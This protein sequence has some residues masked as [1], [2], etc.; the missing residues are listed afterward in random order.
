MKLVDLVRGLNL[1]PASCLND[2]D[3]SGIAYNSQNVKKGFLFVAIK[4]FSTDGHQYI[5]PA[6]MNGASCIAL[7]SLRSLDKKE[8]R[9]EKSYLVC[10]EKKVPFIRF[11]NN[12]ILLSRVSANFFQHPCRQMNVIGITGTNGKTTTT[13]LI[14]KILQEQGYKVGVIGTINYRVNN[15]SLP[16]SATTPESLDLHALFSDMVKQ[17]VRYVVMEVSSHSLSLNRVDDV[18]FDSVI[19]TNLT[20]DHFDFHRNFSGYFRAKRKIFELLVRSEK[21]VKTGLINQD[22][23]YGR[24]LIRQFRQQKSFITFSYGIDSP[25]DLRADN[26]HISLDKTKF[27]FPYKGRRFTVSSGLI[28]KHNVYNILSAAGIGIIEGVPVERIIA[29]VEKLRSVAGRME[30]QKIRDFY[31][32]IDYAHTE[33]ALQNVLEAIKELKPDRIITVFGCGGNR[34]RRKRPHM[35]RVASERSDIVI[36]TSDNPR[37]E[38]PLSIIREVERGIRPHTEYFTIVDRYEAIKKGLSLARA[39]DFLLL[40]GKGH[41]DYQIIG[42]KKFPFDDKEAVLKLS[43]EVP[44]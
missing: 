10:G 18:H 36:I 37:R 20:E 42:D 40:A 33:D 19:F 30:M 29:A 4:G 22:D 43:G 17:K 14:E 5:L 38:D 39:N 34:D 23:R 35:A 27:Q 15:Q 21:K 7:E 8:I 32:G 6:V 44:C 2:L 3:I 25:C 11:R 12:R 13:Y 1:R 28:G 9:I 31:V 26:I 16:A 41:E 24:K